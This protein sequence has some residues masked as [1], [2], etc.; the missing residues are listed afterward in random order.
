MKCLEWEILRHF[1]GRACAVT[2]MLTNSLTSTWPQ[3]SLSPLLFS[4]KLFGLYFHREDRHRRRANDPE[5]NP[6][7]KTTRISSSGLRIYAT[8]LLI[9]AW[10]NASRLFSLFD[11][12]DHFGSV[13]LIKIMIFAA[14]SL[15]AIMYAACYYASHT[16]KLFKVLLTLPVTPDC[17]R[18]ARW[19]A[20][21]ITAIIWISSITNLSILA[22]IRI[23]SGG[24]HDFT[25]APFVTY[26]HVPQEMITVVRFCGYLAYIFIFPGVLFSHAMS[27]VIVYIFCH[28]FKKLKKYFC[29]AVGQ[30]GQFCGDLSSFRRR[31]QTLSSAVDKVDRFLMFSNVGGFI[32]HIVNIIVLL[33]S[34]IFFRESLATPVSVITHIF[35]LMANV[36]GLMF[37]ATAGILVNH[38]VRNC[39]RR[40][41]VSLFSIESKDSRVPAWDKGRHHV[42]ASGRSKI[43]GGQGNKVG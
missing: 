15:T 22:Y 28:E 38:T 39:E 3:L 1:I 13:L 36:K 7:P 6:T 11:K 31:H 30:R 23:A 27:L 17:I 26:V 35:W 21:N 5:W 18:S 37:S 10:L 14:F 24:E 2:C 29:R 9:V 41:T 32:C 4:M 25:V 34:I 40:K 43:W 16:G 12:N 33:Y 19:V 42:F 20:V 8:I